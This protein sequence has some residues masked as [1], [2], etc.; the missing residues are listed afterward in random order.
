MV[1]FGFARRLPENLHTCYL[2]Q[3]AVGSLGK[4]SNTRRWGSCTK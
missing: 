2:L 4:L 1:H 3:L